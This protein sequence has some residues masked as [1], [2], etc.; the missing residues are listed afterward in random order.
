MTAVIDHICVHQHNGTTLLLGIVFSASQVAVYS[1]LQHRFDLT[2]TFG[3]LR[4]VLYISLES[5]STMLASILV[6]K[7]LLAK[8]SLTAC[9]VMLP[10]F[11]H[12][13]GFGHAER[14]ISKGKAHGTIND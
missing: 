3:L 12:D 13:I 6:V 7:T 8:L 2:F 11:C 9:K 5:F 4:L 1:L 14:S 10:Q